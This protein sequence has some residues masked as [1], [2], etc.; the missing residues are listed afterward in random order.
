MQGVCPVDGVSWL[1]SPCR[2]S[3]VTRVTRSVAKRKNPA[4]C[5]VVLA[6]GESNS[7][8]IEPRSKDSLAVRQDHT[9]LCGVN[10]LGSSSRCHSRRLGLYT[11]FCVCLK[12][13]F[14]DRKPLWAQ[15]LKL[16]NARLRQAISFPYPNSATAYAK[17]PSKLTLWAYLSDNL[18]YV[19]ACNV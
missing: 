7:K 6:L 15:Q 19:H 18:I 4:K 2:P 16:P 1:G 17:Q 12:K 9:G 3:N 10:F 11:L 13:L 5:S 8:T 14:N